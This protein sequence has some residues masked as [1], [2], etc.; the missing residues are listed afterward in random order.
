[1]LLTGVLLLALW[2]AILVSA[3]ANLI[4]SEPSTGTV[5]ERAP[6]VVVLEYS[7]A[8][9]PALTAVKLLDASSHVVAAGPGVIDPAEPQVLRLR[10]PPLP[11]GTYSAVWKARS[12]ID[13]H[14]TNGSVGFSVGV[15]SPPASLLPPPGTP[16]PATALPAPADALVRWLSYLAAAVT[17]GSLLFGLF[18][19][20]PAVRRWKGQSEEI[21]VYTT[22][23]LRKLALVG[24]CGLALASL[25]LAIVQA[26]EAGA[27]LWQLLSGRTG[28]LIGM[29][30]A[31]LAVLALLVRRL[32]SSGAGRAGRWW[33]ASAMG[34][35]MLLT[36]SLQSHTAAFDSWLALTLDW[37]HLI[38]MTAWLGGLL[39]L[40]VLVRPTETRRELLAVLVP[41]FSIVALTS[42]GM[43]SVTGL[44]SAIL[45][46]R[47]LDALV[48]TSYG[49]ALSVK[50]GLFALLIGLGAINLLVLS[51]RLRHMSRM[52]ADG[53]RRTVRLELSI[54]MLVLLAVGVLTGVS[55]AFEALE[56]RRRQGWL[57]SVQVG[58]VQLALRVAPARVG[59]NEFGIDHRSL[60]TTTDDHQSH[61]ATAESAVLL[62]L[63]M[64][65]HDMGTTQIETTTRDG[66]R[67]TARGSYLTMGGRW[68][69]EVI[70][71]RPEFNDVRHT[72]DLLVPPV[73][74]TSTGEEISLVNP[75][76]PDARSL[77]A[78]KT[79]YEQHC[80]ACHGASG[81]GDGPAAIRLN[82]R[83]ADLRQ[84]MIPGVHSDAQVFDWISNGYPNS[85][86]PAFAS[87]LSENERWDVLN[88][89]RTFGAGP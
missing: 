28:A 62:R 63:S 23:L 42:V 29:R 64:L 71:R 20:R 14:V 38:A 60:V 52:A 27:P 77:A 76:P 66:L 47:T 85:P 69:V 83:P 44:Y 59:E 22:R 26:A 17:M 16:D 80:L 9:D 24:I 8:L 34:A 2:P 81:R 30:L 5:L 43:L 33:V 54:G 35:G 12:L 6:E 32:P 51:P 45:H 61:A 53:L 70:V 88:Y 84:H 55:P 19:W 56:A 67:Y 11:E 37:V 3:H 89:I 21:E 49:Q 31:L 13:G 82:P 48:T 72:F 1:M 4:R 75:I 10:L 50:V 78:G 39:P 58:D 41:R 7:E 18:V 73:V 36:F 40:S 15:S 79:L 25:G 57:E 74:D 86:M 87:T 65:D 46:V 68:Q